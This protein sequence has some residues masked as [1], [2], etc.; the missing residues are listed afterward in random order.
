MSP[1]PVDYFIP[2]AP[3]MPIAKAED[4]AR[5]RAR[6]AFHRGAW[7]GAAAMAAGI[8]AAEM[9]NGDTIKI[10]RMHINGQLSSPTTVTLAPSSVPGQLA[11]VTMQ[12]EYV[13]QGRD[14]GTYTLSIDGLTID[15]RFTWDK[16]PILGSD[17]IEVAPP[18]GVTC[19]PTDCGIT[20]PEG[21]TGTI[22]LFEFVGF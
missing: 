17:R 10:G 22:V 6:R 2:N 8:F 13:N 4:M 21:Q 7:V 19:Q 5:S 12:N 11:T 1:Q 9:V 15:A 16:D 20:V 14:D 18:V 3:M